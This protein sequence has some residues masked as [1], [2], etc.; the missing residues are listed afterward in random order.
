MRSAGWLG[1][2]TGIDINPGMIAASQERLPTEK[3][4]CGDILSDELPQN[5]DYVMCGATVEHRPKFAE[6]EKYL[7]DMI[8]KMFSL[9]NKGVAFDVFSN[10]VDYMDDDKLY[11]NPVSLLEFCYD[12]TRRLTFRN[13][14][15]PYE[16]VVYLYA[17]G[18]TDRMNIYSEWSTPVLNV[19]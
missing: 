5:Y 6:P 17:D 4:I 11:A 7:H 13:D 19:I 8:R 1:M 18:P 9:A 2:Y 14:C 15:R 3:F 12:L 16:L 10:R